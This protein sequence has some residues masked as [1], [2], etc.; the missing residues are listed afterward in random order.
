MMNSAIL[1]HQEF[2]LA[3]DAQASLASPAP[4]FQNVLLAANGMEHGDGAEREAIALCAEHGAHLHVLSAV[5]P[6]DDSGLMSLKSEIKTARKTQDTLSRL[7]EQ[8]RLAGVD[9]TTHVR[10][11]A[12]AHEVIL[13]GAKSFLAD[14]IVME[15]CGRHGLARLVLGNVTARVVGGASCGVIVVP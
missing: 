9:C 2:R 14:M 4:R 15:R 12:P 7:K 1:S 11:G 8:A 13:E 10:S 3:A 6:S 5:A